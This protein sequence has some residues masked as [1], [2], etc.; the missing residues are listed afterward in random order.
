MQWLLMQAMGLTSKF[1]AKEEALDRTLIQ[2]A[3]MVGDV[4]PKVQRK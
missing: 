3:L 2:E 4:L 1:Q